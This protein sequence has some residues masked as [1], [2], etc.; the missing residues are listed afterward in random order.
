MQNELTGPLKNA[1]ER[2]ENLGKVKKSFINAGY[3][4]R[5][6]EA[7]AA[8]LSTST[9]KPSQL[10]IKKPTTPIPKPKERPKF[11]IWLIIILILSIIILIGAALL[12]FYW[13]KLFN[14]LPLLI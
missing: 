4:P 13:D 9:I 7:A 12:G 2:G 8:E 3:A 1:L 6:V 5:D 10:S 11:P 14:I